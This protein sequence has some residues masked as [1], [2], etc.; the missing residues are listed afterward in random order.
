MRHWWGR[1]IA[2]RNSVFVDEGKVVATLAN[3][4]DSKLALTLNICSEFVEPG[5][6]VLCAQAHSSIMWA[7]E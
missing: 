6:A 3:I 2:L 7:I 4:I 1:E 5:I